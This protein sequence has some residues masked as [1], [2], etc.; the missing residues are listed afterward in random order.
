MTSRNKPRVTNKAPV[1]IEDKRRKMGH[2]SFV[3]P[4][5][6]NSNIKIVSYVKEPPQNMKYFV[7][8]PPQTI[9]VKPKNR[10]ESHLRRKRISEDQLDLSIGRS[11]SQMLMQRVQ[12]ANRISRRNRNNNDNSGSHWL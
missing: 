2:N 1:L 8:S 6:R 5:R 10:S 9:R 4:V 7:Q 11:K 12:T 3:Q